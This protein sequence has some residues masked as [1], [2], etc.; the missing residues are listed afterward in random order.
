MAVQR[1]LPSLPR[2]VVPD[3]IFHVVPRVG[4]RRAEE[5]IEREICDG[6]FRPPD[7]AEKAKIEEAYALFVPF[8]RIDMQRSDQALRLSGVRIGGVPIPH[9]STSEATAT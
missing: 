1:F 5:M 7:A 6:T 4:P 9:Q 2:P 8:W 3:E